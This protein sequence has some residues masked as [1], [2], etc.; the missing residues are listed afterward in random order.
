MTNW[1][2]SS[3]RALDDEERRHEEYRKWKAARPVRRETIERLMA[4]RRRQAIQRPALAPVRPNPV[5]ALKISD[6][7]GCG[8]ASKRNAGFSAPP[9]EGRSNRHGRQP[10]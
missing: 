3:G 4:T 8:R 5:D 7:P 9:P 10:T 2:V 6:N 1:P